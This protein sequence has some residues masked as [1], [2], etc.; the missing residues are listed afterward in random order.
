MLNHIPNPLN[1]PYRMYP[2]NPITSPPLFEKMLPTT[3]PKII[4][5]KL[6][7][8]NYTPKYYKSLSHTTAKLNYPYQH[9]DI[10]NTCIYNKVVSYVIV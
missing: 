5:K 10:I 3:F 8:N 1:D 2:D 7:Q 9:P 6:P 4:P